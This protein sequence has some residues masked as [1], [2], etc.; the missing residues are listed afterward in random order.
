[1]VTGWAGRSCCDF[2]AAVTWFTLH[3]IIYSA[4][5]WCKSHETCLPGMRINSHQLMLWRWEEQQ[6][7]P[8]A[9]VA[10]RPVFS[11][12]LGKAQIRIPWWEAF[13][14]LVSVWHPSPERIPK[15]FTVGCFKWPR[16]TRQSPGGCWAGAWGSPPMPK[17]KG[18]LDQG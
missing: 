14:P 18:R 10:V 4:S 16:S 6:T 15:G 3:H 7:S 12:G 2:I 1:M 8:G 5:L 17:D 11:P 13:V 9:A